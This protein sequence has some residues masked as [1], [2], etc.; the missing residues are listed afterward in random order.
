MIIEL[1]E[2][3]NGNLILP[4]GDELCSELGW[5][6]GDTILWTDLGDE[7]GRAHV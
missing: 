2:D 3:E 5:K 4:L 1:E 7:I 6:V